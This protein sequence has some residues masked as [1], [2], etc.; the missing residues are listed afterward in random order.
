MKKS[1]IKS[2]TYPLTKEEL[3]NIV[4]Q[5]LSEVSSLRI[6]I[7][8]IDDGH[9]FSNKFIIDSIIRSSDLVHSISNLN[10]TNLNSVFILMRSQLEVV[11]DLQ[12]FYSIYLRDKI[13]SDN[14]A[15]RFYQFNINNYLE[16]SDEYEIFI[17][18]DAYLK[19]VEPQ[20]NQIKDLAK[21][22]QKNYIEI[23]DLNAKPRLQ[24]LQK[25]NW[26]ALPG[27]IERKED[28]EFKARAKV[29]ATIAEKISNI[30]DA[31]YYNN[32]KVLNAF[33]HWSAARMNYTDENI[34]EALYLRNL[35]ISLGL[36]FD[37]MQIGYDVKGIN[38]P[39]KINMIAAQ[40]HY[41]NP[42]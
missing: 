8:K 2:N 4:A 18:Q 12:W 11:V 22:K 30:K 23:V 38:P 41:F 10:I 16:I 35:N 13:Q 34:A 39:S 7:E 29:A 20:L 24:R 6:L 31:P 26:R 15:K 1:K 17:H 40:V 5:F 19:K 37:M 33:T 25:I 21:A 28:I 32:W 14:L 9:K 27:L 36:L 42:E 3:D